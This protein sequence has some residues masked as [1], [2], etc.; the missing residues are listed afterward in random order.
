MNDNLQ[1]WDSVSKT[2]PDHTK[3]VSVGRKFT[4]IDPYSQIKKATE[5]FGKVGSG[6]GWE[7]QLSYHSEFNICQ[8]YIGLWYMEGEDRRCIEVYGTAPLSNKKGFDT[9]APKKALTDAITK[10]LSYLGFNAD[11][12]LGQFDDSK[13]VA[14][15]YEEKYQ[16]EQEKL[17]QEAAKQKVDAFLNEIKFF[18]DAAHYTAFTIRENKMLQA[19]HD[20][21]P[22]LFKDVK[23]ALDGKVKELTINPELIWSPK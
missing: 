8:C 7:S 20:R 15:L 6:W 4:A 12:F 21:Q 19:L 10:G 17:K 16:E 9:E 14:S 11:V 22:A 18:T 5:K 1:F 3:Q 23:K 2:D 13:Y